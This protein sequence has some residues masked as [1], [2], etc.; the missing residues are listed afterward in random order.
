[1]KKGFTVIE[2]II[3]TFV[4]SLLIG[5]IMFLYQRSSATFSI[6]LWKQERARQAETFWTHFRKYIEEA[7]D[8]LVIPDSEQG[9]LH[10]QIIIQEK[11]P[12][13]VHPTPADVEEKENILGWNI[14]NLKLDFDSKYYT[15]DSDAY[16]LI[17]DKRKV[18]LACKSKDKP[19]AVLEDVEDINF[20]L[21]PIS[22]SG[23]SYSDISIGTS[24]GDNV[25]GTF[26][27][28]SLTISPPDKYIGSENKIPQNHKFKL[29]V[30][31]D[32]TSNVSY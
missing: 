29:N 14:S 19:I 30:S 5:G 1:M 16:Y 13:L 3:A 28:I 20:V 10:P 26:L 21:K 15:C 32:K 17:K 31:F 27:E 23:R 25:T 9:L 4:V 7:T 18:I 24:S 11:K 2:M 12:L 6:T 22:V 8:L